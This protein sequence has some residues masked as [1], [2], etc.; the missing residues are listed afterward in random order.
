MNL[1]VDTSPGRDKR[2]HDANEKISVKRMPVLWSLSESVPGWICVDL[3]PEEVFRLTKGK[4]SHNAQLDGK[5]CL[6]LGL[7]I[8]RK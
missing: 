1:C 7:F 5:S 2:R 6:H 8:W 4:D 3:F